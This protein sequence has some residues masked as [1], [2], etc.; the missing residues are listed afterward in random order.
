M[1][2]KELGFKENDISNL[3]MEILSKAEISSSEQ[4]IHKVL[5]EL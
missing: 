3:A 1:A 5:K 2:C 4:L